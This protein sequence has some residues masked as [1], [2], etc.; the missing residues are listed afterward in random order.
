MEHSTFLIPL[1]Y[2][3]SL[4]YSLRGTSPSLWEYPAEWESAVYED[5]AVTAC[6]SLDPCS[7]WQR[8]AKEHRG[9]THVSVM[10]VQL[11]HDV[12]RLLGN[13]GW[14]A[15]DLDLIEDEGL[16][17]GGVQGVLHHHGLLALVQEGDDRIG[18]C[19]D[20]EGKENRPQ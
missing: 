10:V 9:H 14:L 16:V 8:Q 7:G 20:Q 1:K 2:F 4:L 13:T 5:T 18:I 11:H 17:P 12:G 3:S 19:V 15:K 6:P